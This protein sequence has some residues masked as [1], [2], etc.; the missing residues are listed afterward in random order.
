MEVKLAN[1]VQKLRRLTCKRCKHT[2]IPRT[3]SHKVCP[4]CKSIYWSIA[5]KRL[6]CEYCGYKWK[7]RGTKDPKECPKC[8]RENY[9]CA[10]IKELNKAIEY[11]ES[12][13]R[14]EV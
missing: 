12:L 8:G 3:E 9:D 10:E 14:Q 5:K 4:N 13:I 6:K 1:E 7:K 2:W 11:M